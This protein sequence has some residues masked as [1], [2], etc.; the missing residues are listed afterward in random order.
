MLPKKKGLILALD[1]TDKEKA[2]GVAESVRNYVDGIKVNYPLVLSCGIG[3][4]REIAPMKYVLCDFKIADIPNTSRL[5]ARIAFENGASGVIVHAFAGRDSLEAVKEIADRFGG[6]VFVVVEMSHPGG[7]EFTARH[8]EEFAR[9]S[10]EA[11]ARGIIAPA[12]R[13]DRIEKLR[14]ILGEDMLILS[15]GVGAQ[16]GDPAEAIR[17]GADYLIVGRSIYEAA[18]PGKEAERLSNLILEQ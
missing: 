15:P 8:A 12:T 7:A 13:P 9:M 3:V 18:E 4:V 14:K 10:K 2:L 5:I 11:G 6:D 17:A 1:L 16:G